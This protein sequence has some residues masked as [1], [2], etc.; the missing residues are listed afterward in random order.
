MLDR[1][2][3]QLPGVTGADLQAV[4]ARHR[5]GHAGHAFQDLFEVKPTASISGMR[6]QIQWQSAE[7]R[8]RIDYE[9]ATEASHHRTD[10][11]DVVHDAA[12]GLAVNEA[13][14]ADV[15]IRGQR[16]GD[17]VG[18]S[19][20]DFRYRGSGTGTRPASCANR[21]MRSA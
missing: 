16:G 2:S 13:D 11:C 12:A 18:I 4:D 1:S 5:E 21:V 8:H 20:R 10:R 6:R 15:G 17:S 14:M 19:G 7:C 3:D 9:P